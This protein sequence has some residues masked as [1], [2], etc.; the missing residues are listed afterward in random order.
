MFRALF[1]LTLLCFL[2]GVFAA[3]SDR[4][5]RALSPD[6]A[7]QQTERQQRY[8]G[9]IAQ[10]ERKAKEGRG[11]EKIQVAIT[12]FLQETGRVPTN[13]TELVS[14]RLLTE[15]PKAP[16][17]RA[18]YYSPEK[19]RVVLV[20]APTPPPGAAPRPSAPAPGAPLPP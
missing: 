18:F 7:G 5:N 3:C 6:E 12:E 14:A 1:S 15:L 2:A 8:Q 20:A 13:L 9:M 4:G 17:G 19:G 11:E 10:A 16:P